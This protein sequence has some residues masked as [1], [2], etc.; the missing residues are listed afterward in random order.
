MT[1]KIQRKIPTMTHGIWEDYTPSLGVAIEMPRKGDKVLGTGFTKKGVAGNLNFQTLK[2]TITFHIEYWSQFWL[3]KPLGVYHLTVF[4]IDIFI[5]MSFLAH[6]DQKVK[7]LF[8][9]MAELKAYWKDQEAI[10]GDLEPSP[11]E[12]D[13]DRYE[14][15]GGKGSETSP[16][17]SGGSSKGTPPATL[18]APSPEASEISLDQQLASMDLGKPLSEQEDQELRELLC[19][20]EQLETTA[21]FSPQWLLAHIGFAKQII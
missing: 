15:Q 6:Q 4:S 21:M 20:L 7:Q 16:T 17:S 9:K 13:D 11:V 5:I 2:P 12:N 19:Q 10:W 3:Q 1:P 14:A 18:S 8:V